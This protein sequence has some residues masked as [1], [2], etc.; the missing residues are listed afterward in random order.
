MQVQKS[1]IILK[2]WDSESNLN[3]ETEFQDLEKKVKQ[4][5][6]IKL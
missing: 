1:E 6:M 4:T 5:F 2:I 3:L